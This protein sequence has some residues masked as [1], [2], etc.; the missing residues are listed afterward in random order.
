LGLATLAVGLVEGREEAIPATEGEFVSVGSRV[1]SAN[2][3]SS[4]GVAWGD[5]NGDGWDD[6]VVANAGE[7]ERNFL[8]ENRGD[9]TLELVA[10]SPVGQV[11]APTEGV[12]WVDFDN[13]GDLDLLV[14]NRTEFPNELF[15][16]D[17]NK[18]LVRVSAG[19][20]TAD[21]TSSTTA[22]W[23]DYDEDG[24]LD[25]WVV[26]RDG[27]DDAL[28]RNRGEGGFS[29]LAAGPMVG[30]GGD[31]RTCA[32][33]DVDADGDLDLY[34][35]NFLAVDGESKATNSLY[36]NR[37]DG[38]FEAMIGGP[39]VTEP[40]L[41]YGVSW[42]DFDADG[43]LDLFVSNIAR[44]DQNA[45][46]RNDGS[47]GFAKV[48]SGPLVT[49]SGGPS[50]GHTWGDFDNDGDLD[51]Y[52]A[53]GTE[54][55]D[56][57]LGYFYRHLGDGRFERVLE[58]PFDTDRHIS[59][60]TAWSDY[61]N[62]G[63]LDIFVANWGGNEEAND[64][65]RNQTSG[66]SWLAI[67]LEGRRSNRMGIGAKLRL[68]VEMDGVTRTQHRWQLLNTGYGSQNAP[69]IHFGLGD[70]TAAQTLEITWPSGKVD[71]HSNVEANRFWQAVEGSDLTL[72]TRR[73]VSTSPANE[74]ADHRAGRTPG[75]SNEN[76]EG[77]T[78]QWQS[79]P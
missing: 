73:S 71:T 47:G 2:G 36:L 63:D 23:A 64:F 20:L 56:D 21:R 59:A 55:T 52:V 77:R 37:G 16:N 10:D 12:N 25:V 41:T 5:F 53:N 65:Y 43:D 46:Y 24:F 79:S 44:S 39:A 9:G 68:V 54:G 34:V 28:Y 3:G 49:D 74:A 60:G 30:R 62:D 57:I 7:G 18:G 8:Y 17:G 14:V 22:C 4:R 11:A 38:S 76:L 32:W 70:A 29:R 48:T 72:D 33:G 1:L 61:D 6:L 78:R 35:G 58:S 27:E 19:D 69:I 66:A 75:T 40:G 45:L 50:K 26:N 42:V 15:R 67:R 31:G 13:D 51:L